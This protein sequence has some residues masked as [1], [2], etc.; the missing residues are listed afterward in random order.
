MAEFD[1]EELDAE[2]S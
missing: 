1:E 2:P